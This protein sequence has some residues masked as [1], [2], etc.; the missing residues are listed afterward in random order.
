MMERGRFPFLSRFAL[1]FSFSLLDFAFNEEIS[2]GGVDTSF[3]RCFNDF[4][5]PINDKLHRVHLRFQ[6]GCVYTL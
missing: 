6:R 2:R 1:S 3:S 4:S 5:F